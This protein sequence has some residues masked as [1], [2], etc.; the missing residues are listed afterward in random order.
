VTTIIEAEKR[1]RRIRGYNDLTALAAL[2]ILDA[3]LRNQPDL[4]HQVA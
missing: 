4:M 1:H 2:A 3:F